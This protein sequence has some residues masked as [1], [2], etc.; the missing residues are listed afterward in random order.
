[1]N[2]E[3]LREAKLAAIVAG[4]LAGEEAA[5]RVLRNGGIDAAARTLGHSGL[6]T[7]GPAT[8]ARF[9]ARWGDGG[10]DNWQG[11]AMAGPHNGVHPYHVRAYDEAFARGAR[12]LCEIAVRGF[13]DAEAGLA[14]AWPKGDTIADMERSI[15]IRRRKAAMGERTNLIWAYE[16]G[17]AAQR[18]M[19]GHGE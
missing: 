4:E 10:E 17:H 11:L 16:M 12:R 18:K 15:E 14:V 1:M 6:G 2:T 8:A 7:V 3:A 9:L 19:V 5:K 13:L